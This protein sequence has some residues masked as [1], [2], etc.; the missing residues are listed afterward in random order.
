MSSIDRRTRPAKRA[1]VALQGGA[2]NPRSTEIVGDERPGRMSQRQA[3]CK[4]CTAHLKADLPNSAIVQS[5]AD[6]LYSRG[7]PL[8]QVH[9]R[10]KALTAEWPA[11]ER[12]SYDSVRRHTLSH[13]LDITESARRAATER[14][15]QM[16]EAKE[17]LAELY[18]DTVVDSTMFL[19]LRARDKV[20]LGEIEPRTF[21]DA[22]RA[23]EAW[24]K[25]RPTPETEGIPLWEYEQDI[26][27]LIERARRHMPKE[28]YKAFLDDLKAV[29]REPRPDEDGGQAE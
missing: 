17:A 28:N 16:G 15:R 26:V 11:S 3:L 9:A 18:I 6:T 5:E 4:I 1:L 27:S 13:V 21:R 8:T 2:A 23:V 7:A 12:P 25:F 14:L 24:S 29:G 19:A 22:L 10:V 20:A